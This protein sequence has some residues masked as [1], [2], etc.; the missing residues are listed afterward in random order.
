MFDSECLHL[1]SSS[2]DWQNL[3]SMI[4]MW[5]KIHQ[6][7]LLLILAWVITIWCL[8]WPLICKTVVSWIQFW[9]HLN[10]PIAT[11]SWV[12]YTYS[13]L[14]SSCWIYVRGFDMWFF[15]GPLC[16]LFVVSLWISFSL[17]SKASRTRKG[18]VPTN[19]RGIRTKRLC[20]PNYHRSYFQR[21]GRILS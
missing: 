18:T 6:Y 12:M 19:S 2:V 9:L 10:F 1:N 4:P 16:A 21:N 5:T 8:S 13:L 15:A 7:K 3:P 17:V 14:I 11:M 20:V